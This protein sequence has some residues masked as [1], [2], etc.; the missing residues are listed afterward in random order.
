MSITYNVIQGDTFENIARKQ[1][2]TEQEAGKIAAANPGV[3][4]PLTPGILIIIPV[5]PGA[6]QNIKQ[7]TPTK[8][9]N[10]TALLIDGNRF[11]FWDSVRI[12]R[13]IDTM[14]VVEFGAPFDSNIPSFRETFRPF[15]YRAVEV[16][17][18]GDVLFTGTL[19]G[20]DPVLE[21]NK[22]IISASCYSL[23]GI[24][25]D[26]TPPASAYPLEFNNQG[27]QEI[28]KKLVEPFGLSVD[29]RADQGAIFERVALDP[30]KKIIAF[31]I[32]LANQRNLIL[33]SNQ[34]GEL[35]V[36]KSVTPGKPVAR[37][38]QGV[39]PL[40]SVSPFLALKI[41]IVTLRV[42]NP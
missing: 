29:F 22:K 6:P 38:E 23:P 27:F 39:T 32:E 1:Y 15:S 17:V 28:V 12:T 20:V 33:S 26:C 14:D 42:F 16:T 19:I 35:L 30:S 41:I 10:E 2:G 18:G 31:L 24:L 13:S 9:E 40:L 8:N 3:K 25:S 7:Q 5:V 34:F 4:E 21:N 36:W 37:L 11:R